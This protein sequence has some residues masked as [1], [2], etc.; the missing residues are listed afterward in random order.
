[1]ARG[2]IVKAGFKVEDLDAAAP[3]QH[4]ADANGSL[5]RKIKAVQPSTSAPK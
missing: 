1:L 4:A 2:Y 5:Y 3:L